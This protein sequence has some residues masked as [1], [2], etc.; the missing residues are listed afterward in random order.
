[1]GGAI[2]QAD[3]DPLQKIT[4]RTAHSFGKFGFKISGVA[5][6]GSDWKHF[7][8]DEYEGHDPAFLG[9]HSLR[10]DKIDNNN[11]AWEQ[12]NPTFTEEMLNVWENSDPSWAEDSLMFSDGISNFG[13]DAEAGSPTITQ[14]MIDE[15]ASDQ[16]QRYTVPGTN[17]TLWFVTQEMLGQGYADGIDNDGDGQIDNGIDEGID[18]YAEVWVDGVDNDNDGEIDESDEQGS[19]WLGRFGDFTNNWTV[20]G[21]GF[22][23]YEYDEDG[24]ILFDSNKNGVYG[25]NWGT[26]GIDNDGD[27]APYFDESGNPWDIAQEEFE[28]LNSNGIWDEGEFL[29]DGNFNGV[30]DDA[31][32]YT[33]QNGVE[34]WQSEES[35]ADNN[36]NEVFDEGDFLFPWTDYDGDGEWDPAEPFEDLNGDGEYSESEYFVDSNGNGIWDPNESLDDIN[37]NGIWD[38][39]DLNDIDGNGLP[40]PYFL[41]PT[42]KPSLQ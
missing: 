11:N 4:F 16:F 1:M 19:E 9:R 33:E 25:D 30:W 5:L 27:W 24:N 35:F 14:E 42:I 37:G 38:Q 23:E 7:N 29:A 8:S 40:S 15:A 41:T 26:D 12:N 18:D 6:R 3:T 32:P 13:N 17:I 20:D 34:G 31:E 22:G 28:D 39:F 10:H 21:G 2:S 36:G